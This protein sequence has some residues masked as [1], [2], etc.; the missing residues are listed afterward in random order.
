MYLLVSRRQ[1]L[2]SSLPTTKFVVSR[3]RS[4][5]FTR[6]VSDFESSLELGLSMHLSQQ[7]SVKVWTNCLN[8]CFSL[9]TWRKRCNSGSA[10]PV[11]ADIL[12]VSS[13]VTQPQ[14]ACT[15]QCLHSGG[16]GGLPEVFWQLQFTLGW[17]GKLHFKCWKI[18]VFVR[19]GI[20]VTFLFDFHCDF[21]ILENFLWSPQ[22]SL[23]VC[24]YWSW[25]HFA[26]I[27]KIIILW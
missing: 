24:V 25:R 26:V 3:N 18:S 19:T 10:I 23:R 16:E 14:G 6:Q 2:S 22:I 7:M 17:V 15:Y 11:L 20:L 27:C 1:C 12:I 8:F 13:Q 4:T 9:S 5:Q 21:I